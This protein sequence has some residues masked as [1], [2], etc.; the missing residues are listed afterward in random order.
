MIGEN[1]DIGFYRLLVNDLG[2]AEYLPKPLTRDTVQRELRPLLSGNNPV[3]PA[4]GT[5]GGHVV[6]VCGARGG[7]GA[8]TIAVSTALELAST[9]KGHVALLDLH[10]RD[11]CVAL[12]LSGRPGPGLRIALEDPG[13]A[14]ALFLDRTAIPIGER[15]KLIAAEEA[16]D[17]APALTEAGVSRVLD[18]LRQRFNYVVVDLPMPPQP[19]MR[20]VIELARHVVVVLEPDIA[21]LRN[22][23]A[24]RNLV[25]ATTG[26]DRVLM[27]LNRADL[28][29]GLSLPL[30]RKGLERE[31]DISIPDLGRRMA[32]AVNL[33]VPAVQ[34]V[35][36]L[37]D[38]IG[39]LIREISGTG[40]KK[41]KSWLQRML[42][43]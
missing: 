29:S 40:G 26:A 27:V 2:V 32:E 36:A 17:A 20:R 35:P 22:A 33:G 37:R 28:K 25:I 31:P 9:T 21:S 39:P 42:G 13:R 19:A 11:G 16:Y 15:L 5:R 41:T 6:A 1:N 30:I 8:T 7:A 10:L 23:R 4:T 12:M 18:L 24:I 3:E 14:D 43:A 38:Q 34:R